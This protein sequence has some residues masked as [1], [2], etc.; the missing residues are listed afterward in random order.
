MACQ[1]LGVDI[2]ALAKALRLPDLPPP[3][4]K[5]VGSEEWA[6]SLP[7]PGVVNLQ[8]MMTRLKERVSKFGSGWIE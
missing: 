6:P 8:K 1:Q 2:E 4:E 5:M 3:K 7:G